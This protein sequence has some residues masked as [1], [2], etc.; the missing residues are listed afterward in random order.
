MA[1]NNNNFENIIGR[2]KNGLVNQNFQTNNN[3]QLTI[4]QDDFNAWKDIVTT[5]L[6]PLH[7][8]NGFDLNKLQ[9][10]IV[11]S[12]GVKDFNDVTAMIPTFNRPSYLP[13]PTFTNLLESLYHAFA[14]DEEGR[15]RYELIDPKNRINYRNPFYDFGC[16]QLRE[17]VFFINVCLV[18]GS[19][20]EDADMRN[21][22]LSIRFINELLSWAAGK[23]R[24][25]AL[26]DFR[27]TQH[28]HNTNF[29][30]NF[31]KENGYASFLQSDEVFRIVN[32]YNDRYY[33]FCHPKEITI[34][35]T[36]FTEL[37]QEIHDKGYPIKRMYRPPN[38]E[39]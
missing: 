21:A 22:V 32:P 34:P 27:L 19:N 17:S 33:C 14:V 7:N 9:M 13:A 36:R 38:E 37:F 35:D 26:L 15:Q 6:L 2:V 28:K 10:I 4:T 20:N 16:G 3:G 24:K 1:E 23:K 12:S 31:S 25:V 18:V 11:G 39:W 8:D 30:G 29:S 5:T